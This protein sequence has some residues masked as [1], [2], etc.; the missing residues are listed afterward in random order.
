M[1]DLSSRFEAIVIEGA[2]SVTELNL[3]DHDLVNL[4]S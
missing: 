2:G 1:S 3:R 4:G